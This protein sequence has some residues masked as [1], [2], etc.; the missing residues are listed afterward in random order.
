MTSSITNG[1]YGALGI[2]LASDGSY[3]VP[4]TVCHSTLPS[5]STANPSCPSTPSTSL[6]S[7]PGSRTHSTA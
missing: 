3:Y 7:C 4:C 6:V 2:N 1:I 5:L